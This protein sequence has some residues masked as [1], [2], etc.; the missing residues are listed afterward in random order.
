MRIRTIQITEIASSGQKVQRKN[1]KDKPKANHPGQRFVQQ[2]WPKRRESQKTWR[3]N[4]DK[5]KREI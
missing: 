4:E 1:R 2:M 5:E 3:K